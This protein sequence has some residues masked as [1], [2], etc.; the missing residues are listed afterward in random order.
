MDIYGF[1]PRDLGGYSSDTR[2]KRTP[3]SWISTAPTRFKLQY[4][5]E[6]EPNRKSESSMGAMAPFNGVQAQ[7]VGCY[8]LNVGDRHAESWTISACAP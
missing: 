1:S 6:L 2:T 8:R 7:Y 5:V 4:D 3:P